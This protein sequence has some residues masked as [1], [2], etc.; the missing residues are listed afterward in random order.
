MHSTSPLRSILPS[1][2]AEKPPT[3]HLGK[4]RKPLG[5]LCRGDSGIVLSIPT[6]L[7]ISASKKAQ[8]DLSLSPLPLNGKVHGTEV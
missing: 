7:G 2:F 4:R 6:R 3:K 5:S 8:S 1:C